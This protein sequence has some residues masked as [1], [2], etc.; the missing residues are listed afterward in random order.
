MTDATRDTGS[1]TVEAALAIATL[2]VVAVLLLAGFSA[3]SAQVRCVD[4]AREAAR[5]VARGEPAARD[6]AALDVARGIAPP[7]ARIQIVRAPG[8]LIRVQ[9]AVPAPLLPGITVTGNAVAVAE[10]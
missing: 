5:L 2:A 10:P 1:S 8:D 7:G 6:A 3:L 4:A 9:V